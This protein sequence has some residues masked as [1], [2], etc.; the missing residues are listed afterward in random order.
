MTQ[1]RRFRIRGTP[2]PLGA[3]LASGAGL[4]PTPPTSRAQSISARQLVRRS[5]GEASKAA[6][7]STGATLPSRLLALLTLC[8]T[9]M[10]NN[11]FRY[12]GTESD[13]G[14]KMITFSV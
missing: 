2:H 12:R 10:R 7:T 13:R 4:L 8:D 1:N 14:A 11:T 6:S 9:K 5:R 3:P